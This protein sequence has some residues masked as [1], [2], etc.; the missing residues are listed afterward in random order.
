M[1]GVMNSIVEYSQTEAA[2]ADLA[3]RYAAVLFDTSNVKGMDSAKKARQKSA[4]I[5]SAWKPSVSR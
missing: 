5:E 2:L 3:D 1:E 4:A